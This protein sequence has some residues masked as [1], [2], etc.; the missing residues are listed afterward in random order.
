MDNGIDL[1]MNSSS[2]R[3]S[4]PSGTVHTP[5]IFPGKDISK[6]FNHKSIVLKAIYLREKNT[7]NS[8]M[9]VITLIVRF[10]KD[11]DIWK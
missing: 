3:T 4:T 10:I 7:K 5:K 2:S 9:V 8:V 6:L 1:R 11:K